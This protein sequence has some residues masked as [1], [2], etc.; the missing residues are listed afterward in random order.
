MLLCFCC[1]G[2]GRAIERGTDNDCYCVFVRVWGG[3][4]RDELI[5]NITVNVARV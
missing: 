5:L 2:L 4:Y 1:E 3:Q